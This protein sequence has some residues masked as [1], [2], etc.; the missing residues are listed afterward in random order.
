VITFDVLGDQSF[1]ECRYEHM[2]GSIALTMIAATTL[3]EDI[4]QEMQRRA[5]AAS[6][7]HDLCGASVLIHAAM[8][9]WPEWWTRSTPL[10]AGR[11]S[12]PEPSGSR[13]MPASTRRPAGS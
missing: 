8:A 10:G 2:F 9:S 11:D 5:T 13:F 7:V 4:A 6:V 3:D 1:V 12:L